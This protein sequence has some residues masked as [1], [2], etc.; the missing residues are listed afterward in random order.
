[1]K[2]IENQERVMP[3]PPLQGPTTNGHCVVNHYF[4]TVVTVYCCL[5]GD[6][7]KYIVI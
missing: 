1:M 3:T 6:Y 7:S 5:L 4:V 2:K